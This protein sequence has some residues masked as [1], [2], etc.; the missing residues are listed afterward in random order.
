M[1]KVLYEPVRRLERFT[2]HLYPALV[3]SNHPDILSSFKKVVAACTSFCSCQ[4]NAVTLMYLEMKEEKNPA[5][6]FW[7]MMTNTAILM[8]QTMRAKSTATERKA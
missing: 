3:T 6:S 7:I 8:R 2:L 5:L 4:L 1:S